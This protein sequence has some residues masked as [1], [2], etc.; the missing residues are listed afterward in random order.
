MYNMKKM[1]ERIKEAAQ[2]LIF[3]Q[4]ETLPMVEITFAPEGGKQNYSIRVPKAF[5]EEIY[6]LGVAEGKRERRYT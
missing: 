5:I 1:E 2:A 4:E 3:E 6:K